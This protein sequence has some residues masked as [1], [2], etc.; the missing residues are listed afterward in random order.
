MPVGELKS[1]SMSLIDVTSSV[2]SPVSPTEKTWTLSPGAAVVAPESPDAVVVSV[3][4]A[5]RLE[6]EANRK[7]RGNKVLTGRT[8]LKR[9]VISGADNPRRVLTV[10]PDGTAKQDD[11]DI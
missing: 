10:P 3:L 6:G 5:E 4:A 2:P 9:S 11:P 8:Q 1:E 7:N